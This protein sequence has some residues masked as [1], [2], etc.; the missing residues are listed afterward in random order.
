MRRVAV[1]EDDLKRVYLVAYRA[2][3]KDKAAATKFE[4]ELDEATG[5]KRS[6]RDTYIQRLMAR[7]LVRVVDRGKVVA[8]EE[9]FS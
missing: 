6:S 3:G 5:Y 7:R 9:L 1:D 8:S 2:A 4:D